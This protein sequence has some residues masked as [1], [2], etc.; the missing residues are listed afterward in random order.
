M[1]STNGNALRSDNIYMNIAANPAYI[2]L[3]PNNNAAQIILSDG[4]TTQSRFVWDQINIGYTS[5]LVENKEDIAVSSTAVIETIST[6]NG[7]NYLN[8]AVINCGVGGVSEALSANE[9]ASNYSAGINL[10]CI[11][12]NTSIGCGITYPTSPP[13]PNADGQISI[14]VSSGSGSLNPSLSL[15]SSAPFT[16]STSTIIDKNGINQNNSSGGFTLNSNANPLALTTTDTM[17]FSADNID[18]SSTGRLILPS[19]ASADR[20]D[21]NAGTLNLKTDNVG[22]TTDDLLLLENTNATAGNTTGVPS[23][24][25]YKSGRNG[26]TNDVVSTILFNAK[27]GAGVK[28]T[29]GK[30]ESSITTNTAPANYDGSLDFYS[31]IN[32]VNNLVFRLNGADNENNSFRPLDLN[33]NSLKTSTGDLPIDATASTGTGNIT[34]NSKGSIGLTSVANDIDLNSNTTIAAAKTLSLSKSAAIVSTQVLNG[35]SLVN[36]NLTNNVVATLNTSKL[37]ILDTPNNTYGEF[38]KDYIATFDNTNNKSVIIDNQVIGNPNENRIDFFKN[39]GGGI[40]TTSGIVNNPSGQQFFMN[41]QDNANG[42]S[43]SLVNDSA[44]GGILQYANQIAPQPFTID[45]STGELILKTIAGQAL[46]LSSDIL[47]L[48]N[49]NTTTTANN[50]NADIRTTST[51]VSTATFLKLQLNGVD[52]WVPYFTTDPSL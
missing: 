1:D 24:E 51:G 43:L 5:G 23:L 46:T 17:T 7:S 38:R 36:S 44:S 25:M 27:D 26:A 29:F 42:R 32:G 19:L 6:T 37:E 11:P 22:Y 4:S 30:I 14:S 9:Y 47:N 34:I 13:F 45:S 18:L 31:L 35:E 52:I 21:Y 10:N 40:T 3:K 12:T 2:S 16:P 33:G 15:S 20:L 39:S 8:S 49:T 28:R 41:Y 48:S 50:H